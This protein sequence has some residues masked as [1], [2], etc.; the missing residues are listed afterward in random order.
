MKMASMPI[1]VIMQRRT[2]QHRWADE[3]WSAVGV[4]PDRGNLPRLQILSE[5]CPRGSAHAAAVEPPEQVA[6][7]LLY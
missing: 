1:A 2:V 5:R 7:D 6:S 4:V 3:A